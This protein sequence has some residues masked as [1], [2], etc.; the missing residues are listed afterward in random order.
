MTYLRVR[1][2]SELQHYR[3]RP[4]NPWIKFHVKLLEDEELNDLPIP[5]RLLWD[6]LLLL[7][8]RYAN[9]IPNDPERLANLTR[10]PTR[11]V[12]EGIQQLL[13]G[14][15]LS[16]TK[17]N[18]RASKRASNG[19][20]ATRAHENRTEKPYKGSNRSVTTPPEHDLLRWQD[21]DD[22]TPLAL[23]IAAERLPEPQE[24]VA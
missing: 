9:A 17:G 1:K 18:R 23:A 21:T 15:W 4:E 5:T 12:R 3:N 2:F 10:I 24:Q 13:K 8:Q 11:N 19:A 16:E 7:A 20:S 14:G 22:F 6:R